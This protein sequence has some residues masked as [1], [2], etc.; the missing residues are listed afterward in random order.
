M[1][2]SMIK[3]LGA[4]LVAAGLLAVTACGGPSGSASSGGTGQFDPTQ[5]VRFSLPVIGRQ[6]DPD[7]S[8]SQGADTP[9]MVLVY[10]RLLKLT[11]DGGIAPQLATSYNFSD[12]GLELTFQLRND[13]TFH[14]GQHFDANTVVANLK[15]A[16]APES[17]IASQL[18]VV[19]DVVATGQ[20]E[21]RL[22]LKAPDPTLLFRLATVTGAM[23]SPAALNSPNLQQSPAGSGPYTL[24]Q[25]TTD[26]V[27][28]AK[29]PNYWDHDLR[30]PDRVELIAVADDSARLNLLTSGG[31][32]IINVTPATWLQAKDLGDTDQYDLH[33]NDGAQQQYMFLNAATPPLNNPQVR[34][35]LNLA[36]DR[37]A[38]S[39]ALDGACTPNSQVL[40][41]S[42][43]GYVDGLNYDYN[44]DQAKQILAQQGV[45][46]F[47]I[48]TLESNFE[49]ARTIAQMLQGMLAKIGVTLNLIPTEP[50]LVRSVFG[51][52]K[53]GA[54]VHQQATTYPDPSVLMAT[55]IGGQ[56]DPGG[57]GAALAPAA[58]AARVL[59]LGSPQRAAAYQDLSRQLFQ[60]PTHIPVCNQVTA[61][62]TRSNMVGVDQL[63]FTQVSTSVDLRGVGF[64]Q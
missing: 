28:L 25:F 20:Y 62:L 10:D 51:Q 30:V 55:Q 40:P 56:L 23:V 34:R 5:P 47:T 44:V 13:V 45:G 33:V 41:R 52:G 21:V 2:R 1:Y 37:D 63:P 14:D 17:T 54:M 61:L 9:M 38:I 12:N 42:Y 6:W 35:A 11:G 15:R 46:S 48:E 24:Q 27:V 3:R 8:V 22:T 16:K 59:P 26:H 4:L 39:K 49:P 32:D 60:Q 36:I 50:A 29:N 58:D 53:Y 64:T 19:T 57:A 43:P 7:R 18:A 31:V